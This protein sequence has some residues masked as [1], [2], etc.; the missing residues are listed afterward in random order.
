[1][2]TECAHGQVVRDDGKGGLFKG[3]KSRIP[4]MCVCLTLKSQVLNFTQIY[5]ASNSLMCTA[6]ETQPIC[7]CAL[8]PILRCT[9]KRVHTS[10]PA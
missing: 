5:A 4:Q 6:D 2:L 1:M 10:P 7:I 9:P 3:G 8:R